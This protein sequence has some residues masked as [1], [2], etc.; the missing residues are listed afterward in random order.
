MEAKA[1]VEWEDAVEPEAVA[2]GFVAAINAHDLAALAGWMSDDH[3]LLGSLGNPLQGRAALRWAWRM[4]FAMVPDYRL[5]IH[6]IY[7]RG[8]VVVLL[9][10]TSGT[11]APRGELRPGNQWVIPAAWRAV[12]REGKVVEWRVYA[13][14]E[15]LRRLMRRG[16]KTGAVE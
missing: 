4:Y 6:E 14:N 2:Q 5:E 12:V 13:D 3:R 11:Y 8:E 16:S 9:G 15:P 1:I 10:E 7:T